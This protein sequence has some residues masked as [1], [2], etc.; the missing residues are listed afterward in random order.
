MAVVVM[1]IQKINLLG[2]V[3]VCPQYRLVDEKQIL[4]MMLVYFYG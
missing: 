1:M 2:D 3:N 4:N